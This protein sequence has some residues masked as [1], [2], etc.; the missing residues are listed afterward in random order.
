MVVSQEG[1]S[2]SGLWGR[3]FLESKLRLPGGSQRNSRIWERNLVSISLARW[4]TESHTKTV[5]LNA[6]FRVPALPFHFDSEES[7]E[8]GGGV[9]VE[10]SL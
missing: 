8:Q 10:E 1:E 4:I 7:F 5:L 3:K 6:Q 2:I 9:N